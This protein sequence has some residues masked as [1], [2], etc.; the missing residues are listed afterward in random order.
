MILLSALLEQASTRCGV[1]PQEDAFSQTQLDLVNVGSLWIVQLAVLVD[2]SI[3]KL[4]PV[5]CRNGGPGGVESSVTA[6]DPA[7][8]L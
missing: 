2:I 3:R 5:K 4:D 1:E 6:N 7:C 8:N